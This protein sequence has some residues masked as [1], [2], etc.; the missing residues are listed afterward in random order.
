MLQ[1]VPFDFQG[2]PLIAEK[3]RQHGMQ[4]RKARPWQAAD[5][6]LFPKTFSPLQGAAGHY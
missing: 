2:L 3:S 4:Q 1:P 5:T 6:D